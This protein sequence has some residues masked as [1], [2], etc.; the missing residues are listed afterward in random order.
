MRRLALVACFACAAHPAAPIDEPRSVHVVVDAT[1]PAQLDAAIADAVARTP[2][3]GLAVRIVQGDRVLLDKAYG[4]IDADHTAPL[5]P[6]TVFAIG[7][8]TKQFTAAAILQL[9]EAGV[10]RLD[11]PIATYVPQLA[12][13]ITIQQLLWQT[14]G[15]REN[16]FAELGKAG[17]DAVA[18]IAGLGTEF[19]AGTRWAYNNSNYFVLGRA[20]E[21][22]SGQ[23][24]ADYLRDHVFAAAGLTST[25]VC[26]TQRPGAQPS[27]VRGDALVAGTPIDMPFA[28]AAGAL[29]STTA[30]LLRWQTALFD[31][32]IISP[33]S[34]AVMTDNGALT[35]GKR[36]HYGA[37]LVSD[38][39]AK[40]RRIW[41]NGVLT[42][43]YQSQL[44]YYPDDHLRIVLLAN[45]YQVQPV[46]GR[47]EPALAR[48]ALGIKTSRAEAS[49]M[50]E[51]AG[52]YRAGQVAI[53]IK[54]V[55]GVLHL[56][57]ADEDHVLNY[58]DHDTFELDGSGALVVHLV[59][60]RGR[61]DAIELRTDTKLV[62]R[63][64]R[65]R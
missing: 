18:A 12:G 58:A 60:D 29:C 38:R 22:A 2:L 34:L 15:L 59:R 13:P 24:Y 23:P 11:D 55:D 20:V 33:R 35:S 43:G 5:A 28:D 44:A 62:L 41:H 36:T 40:H 45:T 50:A 49:E 42:F 63:L 39:V 64:R 9:V 65:M 3:L 48:I 51:V 17:D 7:S 14:A 52:T 53:E 32:K 46:L 47:L 19:P 57:V 61:I 56:L 25:S 26:T 21:K 4:F 6:D 37:G 10:L 27:L 31:G 16:V 8:L 30:D 1:V 54:M